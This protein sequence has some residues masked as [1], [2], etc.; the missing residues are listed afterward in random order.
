[1]S[2]TE[3]L[4]AGSPV[5]AAGT[6][7]GPAVTLGSV[8][9][10]AGLTYVGGAPLDLQT[11]VLGACLA[12]GADGLTSLESGW[13]I[14]TDGWPLGAAHESAVRTFVREAA[15]RQA[16]GV[17]IRLGPLWQDVPTVLLD[18]AVHAGITV[19][20]LA[21]ETTLST[22]LRQVNGSTGIH[23][24]A[25]LSTAIG[26]QTELIGA[27]SAPDME[28]ELVRRIANSLA[29]T[30]I[31]YDGRRQA[32]AAQG[33]APIHL[34]GEY[35][36]MAHEGEVRRQVG[37]WTASI[38]AL[39]SG[40]RATHLVLAWPDGREVDSGLLRSTRVAVQQ[41]LRAHARTL[42]SA[43]LQDQIQRGQAMIEILDGVTEARL[44]RMR[45][46][47]VLLHFPIT[48]SFQVHV[49]A[50]PPATSTESAPDP[51]LTLVQEIAD[52]TATPALLGVYRG[53][54]A[55]VHGASDAFTIQLTQ[56]L[57]D[58]VHGASSAFH[59]LT[60]APSALRQA[61]MSLS[62]STRTGEFT[63]FHRV[64]FIDF[65]LGS[66]PEVTLRDRASAV[67]GDLASN[68][69]QLETLIEYLRC[70]LD[71][72]QTG[73]VMHLHPNSI[74]YRLSRVEDQLGRSINDPETITLLYLTLHDSIT[75][76]AR[77]RAGR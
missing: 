75:R 27:L 2:V 60:A 26:L 62:T 31:L 77:R 61:Q 57:G 1:M 72:Q 50:G 34:I 36:D 24:V 66:V 45:D 53:D 51:V 32:L 54:Y 7:V 17:V 21:Q 30:A 16:A 13:L 49:V 3:S 6:P 63:P 35:L 71:I 22:F 11:P 40:D 25:V 10:V 23:D 18:E 56:R 9:A 68:E 38:G 58:S 65:I 15:A 44:Q 39:S 37:R 28:A 59:D 12:E 67:L 69:T 47:L 74:R 42:A 14:A 5:P 33:D 20:S 43:R 46:G 8:A 64:G 76:P 48:G 19:H 73:R 52:A 55:V 41:L 4:P 70:G 29:V